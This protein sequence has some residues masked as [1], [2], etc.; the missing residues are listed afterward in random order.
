M[1]GENRG[2]LAKGEDLIL[3]RRRR[4]CFRAQAAQGSV[5]MGVSDARAQWSL[6]SQHSEYAYCCTLLRDLILSLV[7]PKS[8]SRI[9]TV[10]SKL[11][12]PPY[13]MRTRSLHS[14]VNCSNDSLGDSDRSAQLQ[15]SLP[16]ELR[17]E[18]SVLRH[19]FPRSKLARCQS[20]ETVLTTSNNS[21][22]RRG[23]GIHRQV[24]R[25][26]AT[27]VSPVPIGSRKGSGGLTGGVRRSSNGEG[28]GGGCSLLL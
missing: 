5:K 8:W 20:C 7:P 15:R 19:P 6:N 25:T 3:S 21:K 1:R 28:V 14:A 2:R 11:A 9:R 23:Y 4:T 10:E 24:T 26:R 13:N 16:C 27:L 18:S 22:S 12:L 17:A